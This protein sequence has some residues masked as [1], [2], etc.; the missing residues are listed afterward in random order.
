MPPGARLVEIGALKIVNNQVADRFETL[1]NPN[2]SIPFHVIRV[3][4][5][6]N[7]MVADAPLAA[8]ALSNFTS[9]C[10]DL[11]LVGHN[12]SFDASMIASEL[13][14]ANMPILNNKTYCTLAASRKLLD[15]QSN[16]LSS[17]TEALDLPNSV[18]HRALADAENTHHLLL[19][20]SE[21][22]GA[23]RCW[24]K[25]DRGKVLSEFKPRPVKLPPR[26]RALRSALDKREQIEID[27]R[28]ANG[29]NYLIKIHPRI[30]YESGSR[31]ILEAK[32]DST[33]IVKTY[34]LDSILS[35]AKK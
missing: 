20:I 23:N 30:I 19:H 6:D 17:L 4:G 34:L 10:E 24:Q 18:S 1:I 33:G 16:A 2:C 22:V 35:V 28:L 25:M 13:W 21:L 15:Q 31:T 26:F 7:N 14:R 32:C 9:W 29:R 27:Y 11:P 3:H 12:I 5:I 8:E